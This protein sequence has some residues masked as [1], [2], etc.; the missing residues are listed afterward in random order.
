LAAK[1]EPAGLALRLVAIERLRTVLGGSNFSPI[2]AAELADS[3]DR[4]IAN[5]LVTTALR[6]HGHLNLVIENLLERGMPSKSG[7]FEATLRLS[8]AQLLYLPDLGD[9]SALYLAVEALRRDKRATH[10]AGLMNAMLR[11]AQKERERLLEPPPALLFP[12]ALRKAWQN[13][14]GVEAVGRFAA[15]LLAGTPL[16]LTLKTSDP[17]LLEALGAEALLADTVR[18]QNRDKAV[19]ALPGYAEGQWWVQ[20]VA[21]ALPAR[22][23][24]LPQGASVLDLCAAPGGKTAQL[25][26]AGYKVTALD[27][28][29]GRLGRLRAN[30]Q[31]L[32]YDAEIVEADAATFAP[33]Q[34]FDAVLLDAPCSATGTFRRHP[35]VI[36]HREQSDIAGR[37][38]LQQKLIARAAECLKPGGILIYCVCSLEAAEGESQA[39][40]ALSNVPGLKP[41]PIGA[42]ELGGLE[43]AVTGE[44]TV[45][46]HPGLALP[47]RLAGSL[48]G[49]FIARFRR[50]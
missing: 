1:N 21:A 26:K 28:D 22:L 33:E 44:G 42:E 31:R 13:A 32:H 49:F 20:D 11:R 29:A 47:N 43:R 15:A 34:K 40:W 45:R 48:D 36:W 10:L 12:E 24:D 23:I 18:I 19:D 7:S 35:E 3:R 46:T 30:L 50:I 8:L 5:R 17:A 6:R 9:H 39:A 16:D 38:K 2:T 37:V 14:Y 4:A 27:N 25:V 41:E